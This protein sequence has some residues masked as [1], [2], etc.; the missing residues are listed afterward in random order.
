MEDVYNLAAIAEEQFDQLAVYFVPDASVD[1][2]LP[3]NC[4]SQAEQSLPRNLVLKPSQTLSDVSNYS[5][6]PPSSITPPPLEKGSPQSLSSHF[7]CARLSSIFR[8]LPLPVG[9]PQCPIHSHSN[10]QRE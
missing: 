4:S 2:P 9:L 3:P 7:R 6:S 5:P 10:T 8:P 1:E